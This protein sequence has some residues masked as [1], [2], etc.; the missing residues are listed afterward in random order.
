MNF[1]CDVKPSKPVLTSSAVLIILE[2][3]LTHFGQLLFYKNCRNFWKEMEKRKSFKIPQ[4]YINGFVY[5]KSWTLPKFLTS[6]LDLIRIHLIGIHLIGFHLI[7]FHLIGQSWFYR[8]QFYQSRFYQSWFDR[9][10]FDRSQFD[11]SQFY[12]SQ[13]D[14]SQF[15]WSQ[16]YR[17]QFYRSQRGSYGFDFG[18]ARHTLDQIIGGAEPTLFPL[19]VIKVLI[20][21]GAAAH[22][23]PSLTPSLIGVNWSRFDQNQF[24]RLF[25]VTLRMNRKSKLINHTCVKMAHLL[26]SFIIGWQFLVSVTKTKFLLWCNA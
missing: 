16:F 10:W 20:I 6:T 9:S 26:S 8:S 12:R 23:A 7:G 19:L 15:D 3:H 13:F 22:P 24:S 14:R 1:L 11:R 4:W 21:G 25:F 18:G 17:N 5:S 2:A